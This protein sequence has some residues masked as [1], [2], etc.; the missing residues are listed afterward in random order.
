VTLRHDVKAA[1]S[2]YKMVERR[3]LEPMLERARAAIAAGETV[4][5]GQL[6]ISRDGLAY[7]EKRLGWDRVERLDV[8]APK[9]HGLGGAV[10]GLVAA[11][12]AL[13]NLRVVVKERRT[14]WNPI[15]F[16]KL[17]GWFPTSWCSVPFWTLPNRAVLLRLIVD[18]TPRQTKSTFSPALGVY[19]PSVC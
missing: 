4:W 11:S 19:M 7:D 6:G 1:D 5:F 9:N 2:L 12:A 13:N 3:T 16:G 18:M 15:L 10:G 17:D 8:D 14:P